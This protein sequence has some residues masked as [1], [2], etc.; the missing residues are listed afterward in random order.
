MYGVTRTRFYSWL[1]WDWCQPMAEY[2]THVTNVI[3]HWP[4][5]YF[6]YLIHCALYCNI[7][8]WLEAARLYVR[9]FWSFAISHGVDSYTNTCYHYSGVIM[10]ARA[11]QITSVS[12][13]HPT[14][15]SGANQRKHE[16]SA[17]MTFV[18]GIPRTKPSNAENVSIWWRHYDGKF[19]DTHTW[20]NCTVHG[21]FAF[22]YPAINYDI[23]QRKCNKTCLCFLGNTSLQSDW[24]TLHTNKYAD[25]TWNV[26]M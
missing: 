6:Y 17:S 24:K 23:K 10:N 9:I 25:T 7:C 1:R 16:S 3:P 11:S 15:Y 2:G 22:C 26:I 21:L 19:N 13:V 12:I 5:S 14:V 18:R 8:G 4:R 20:T